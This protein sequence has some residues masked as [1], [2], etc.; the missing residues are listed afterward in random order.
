MDLVQAAVSNH[1]DFFRTSSERRERHGGFEL[2]LHPP[3]GVLPFP[4][5][6]RGADDVVARFRPLGLREVGCWSAAEDPVLATLLVARGFQWGW[7]PHWMGLD[8]AR[9]PDE[10]PSWPI[11][12]PGESYPD[13]LPYRPFRPEPSRRIELTVRER[14]EVV[15]RVVLNPWRGVGSTSRGSTRSSSPA[16]TPGGSR[17]PALCACC[18]TTRPTSSARA[19]AASR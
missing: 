9:L 1:R 17:R 8:L 15:G 4:R 2:L 10:E 19:S 12:G 5:S 6:R 14:G 7:Q 3:I 16:T 13:E 18:R 11:E